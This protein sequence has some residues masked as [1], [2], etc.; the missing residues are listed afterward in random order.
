MYRDGY[1]ILIEHN[2]RSGNVKPAMVFC[3]F[4]DGVLK[5]FSEKGGIMLGSL[6]LPGRIT[7]VKAECEVPTLL[8]HRFTVSSTEVTRI[9]GRRIK[10][11]E[12]RVLEFSAPTHDLMKEWANSMHLWRRMNWKD[13]VTFFETYERIEHIEERALLRSFLKTS[14]D[15]DRWYL[16]P[17]SIS[18]MIKALWDKR[19]SQIA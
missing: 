14:P 12:T 18:P 15:K 13:N 8:P 9:E 2:P 5:F 4:S 3:V 7:K 1:L 6:S 11:G 17:R 16:H 19:K 10:L